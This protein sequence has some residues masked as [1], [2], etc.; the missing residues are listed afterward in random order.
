M[1]GKAAPKKKQQCGAKPGGTC[2]EL[3]RSTSLGTRKQ[4][5][6]RESVR[7][8]QE[9]AADKITKSFCQE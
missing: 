9:E 6:E 5:K 1:S 3:L 8:A 4:Q 2:K 7:L